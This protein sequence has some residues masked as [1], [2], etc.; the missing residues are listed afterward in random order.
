MFARLLWGALFVTALAF[1]QGR[2][3]GMGGD[4]G[5]MGGMGGAGGRGGDTSSLGSARPA[6]RQSKLEQ[7]SDKLRLN[8]SQNEQLQ[9]ILSKARE[10]AG[11][12]RAKLLKAREAVA[13]SMVGGKS[14]QEIDPLVKAYE[15]TAAEMTGVE[16]QAFTRIYAML[17]PNQQSKADQAFELMAGMFEM[18]EAGQGMGRGR[19]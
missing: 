9:N 3:G 19:Q 16:T 2:G 15:A 14:Q 17:K 12:V 18:P 4:E 13:V 11:P 1:A 7:I 8:K 6:Q 5:G 10:E